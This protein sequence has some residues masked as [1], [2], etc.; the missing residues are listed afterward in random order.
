ML[1]TFASQTFLLKQGI[2]SNS[3]LEVEVLFVDGYWDLIR[4]E[5]LFLVNGKRNQIDL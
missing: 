3:V 4:L 2:F 1:Y 5:R